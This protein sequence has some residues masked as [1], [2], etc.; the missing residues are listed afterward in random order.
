MENIH[1]KSKWRT[2]KN[3]DSYSK[4]DLSSWFEL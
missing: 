4:K 1:N 2:L 3:I